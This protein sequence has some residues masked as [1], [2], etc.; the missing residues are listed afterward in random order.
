MLEE[1]IVIRESTID[2]IVIAWSM[3]GAIVI[4]F[5]AIIKGWIPT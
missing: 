1:G 5:V 4:M 2:K 3:F